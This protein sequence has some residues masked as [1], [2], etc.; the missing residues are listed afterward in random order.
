MEESC[1]KDY[2]EL[3][4][5][6]RDI[7]IENWILPYK[8]SIFSILSSKF[9]FD[10]EK[11]LKIKRN[12][13]YNLG[14]SCSD[15]F[16]K[17]H[18]IITEDNEHDNNEYDHEDYDE[19]N[20]F[21]LAVEIVDMTYWSVRELFNTLKNR[22]PDKSKIYSLLEHICNNISKMREISKNKT[23]IISKS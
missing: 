14:M 18:N 8:E 21:N 23:K 22:Y 13:L 6:N 9:K 3:Y 20:A 17:I 19:D 2:L 15:D 5:K 7:A 16:N 11:D 10:A 12:K 4:W 1:H